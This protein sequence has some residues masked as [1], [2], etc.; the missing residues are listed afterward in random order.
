MGGITSVSRP[1]PSLDEMSR[2][3]SLCLRFPS[4]KWGSQ[5][6]WFLKVFLAYVSWTEERGALGW[7]VWEE[8]RVR[9]FLHQ[10]EEI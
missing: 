4:V 8:A 6:S 10:G 3:L 9:W 2:L 1:G 7:G 5:A